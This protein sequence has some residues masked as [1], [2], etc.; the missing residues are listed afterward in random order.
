MLFQLS[1]VLRRVSL[2]LRKTVR[3]LNLVEDFIRSEVDRKELENRERNTSLM[4]FEVY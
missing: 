1:S 2:S 3:S 4:K